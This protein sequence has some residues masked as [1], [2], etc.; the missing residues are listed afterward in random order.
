[1]ALTTSNVYVTCPIS[2]NSKPDPSVAIQPGLATPVSPAAG[3]SW[4][5]ET[6][7]GR[8]GL[9]WLTGCG[10][11]LVLWLYLTATVSAQQSPPTEHHTLVS[12]QYLSLAELAQLYEADPQRAA[13]MN[14]LSPDA[15]VRPEQMVLMPVPIETAIAMGLV[16]MHHIH[17]LPGQS[18]DMVAWQQGVPEPWLSVVNGVRPGTRL[19]PGQPLLVP[20]FAWPD[21]NYHIGQV[22]VEYLSPILAQGSTGFVTLAVPEGITP[23][24]T[25][26]DRPLQLS[27]LTTAQVADESR[28]FFAHIPVH[29]LQAPGT[30]PLE[31]AYPGE[32]GGVIAASLSILIY[33]PGH[34]SRRLIVI[35]DDVAATLTLENVTGEIVALQVKW[36]RFSESRWST[37]A[38]RSPLAAPYPTTSPFGQRRTYQWDVPAPYPVTFHSGHDFAA[39]TG[40]EVQAPGAGTVVLAEELLTKGKA[41][42]LDHGRGVLTGYWHL[43]DLAVAEGDEV[44]AGQVL[45]RVG[46]TGISLGSHLHWELRIQGVPVNPLQFLMTTLE[47]PVVSRE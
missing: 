45:G 16:P 47:P 7:W 21:K 30:W 34:F 35:P 36:D 19:F 8:Y 42:I 44:A 25:W 26:Q 4:S 14:V 24:L 12:G 43:H 23:E 22:T 11:G 9:F 37:E 39:P 40:T 1:M 32:E 6:G 18:L 2:Q 5:R 10:L 33:D 27:P 3:N 29:P 13:R 38:W 41:V 28:Q 46:N 17:A 31:I 15:T 20:D